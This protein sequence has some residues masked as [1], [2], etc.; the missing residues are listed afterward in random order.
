[1]TNDPD[2]ILDELF[3]GCAFSAFLEEAHAQ[4]GWPDMEA[5][6]RR[7]FAY[8]EQKLAIKNGRVR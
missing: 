5:V 8:Y 7:A 4:Q 2:E 6:R 3:H 1:M